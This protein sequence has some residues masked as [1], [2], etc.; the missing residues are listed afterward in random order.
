M[1]L[2]EKAHLV[3]MIPPTTNSGDLLL[4]RNIDVSK[5]HDLDILTCMGIMTAACGISV[6]KLIS[7]TASSSQGVPISDYVYRYTAAPSTEPTSA[8]TGGDTWGVATAGGT[9]GTSIAAASSDRMMLMSV[10]CDAFAAGYKACRVSILNDATGNDYVVVG[11]LSNPRYASD[12]QESVL[13][14]SYN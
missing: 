6:Q 1:I 11:I 9:S 2:E 8:T 13:S 5:Y 4:S 3:M 7:T 12:F 10:N 14:S